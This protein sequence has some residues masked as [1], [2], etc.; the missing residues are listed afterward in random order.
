MSRLPIIFA[1]ALL[2]CSK[3]APPEIQPTLEAIRPE[4][5]RV[6]DAA[7]KAC[8]AQFSSGRFKVTPTSCSMEKLPGETMV[9]VV[10]SPAKGTSL[11][12]NPLV[13]DVTTFCNAPTSGNE[14]C[15]NGL[16]SLH[17]A[18]KGPGAGRMRK[19]IDGNC[20]S[21]S[22]DCEDVISPSQSAADETSADLRIVKPVAGG[23]PG[24]TAEV[25]IILAKK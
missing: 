11:E 15:G 14:S 18:I 19:V 21:S 6:A 20:K 25:T 23:P 12:T 16:G 22:T 3:K 7:A 24:A 8:A 17:N 5:R 4:A 1:L 9:P 2:G 10:D 13:L